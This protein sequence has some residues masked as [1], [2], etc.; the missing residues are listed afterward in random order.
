MSSFG[1]KWLVIRGVFMDVVSV[2][3]NPPFLD[4]GLWDCTNWRYG[5]DAFSK[6]NC[7][8]RCWEAMVNG[9]EELFFRRILISSR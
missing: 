3:P 5:V 2:L 1:C 9:L 7:A 4:V 6:I 8:M